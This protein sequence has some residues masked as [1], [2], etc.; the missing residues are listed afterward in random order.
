MI[1][2]C[3]TCVQIHVIM[4]YFSITSLNQYIKSKPTRKLNEPEVSSNNI[5]AKFIFR[6]LVDA[7]RYCH[8]KN[9]V[10]RDIKLENVLI[11]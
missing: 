10:H 6:Q 3:E 1:S 4:E 7:V 5:K 11:D 2:A 9:V 8:Y